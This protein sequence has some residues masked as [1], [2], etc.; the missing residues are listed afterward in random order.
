MDNKNEDF[1]FDCYSIFFDTCPREIKDD[2]G[3]VWTMD[4]ELMS[5]SISWDCE[6]LPTDW[7]VY[8][9]PYWEGENII[10]FEV[11]DDE[12]ELVYSRHTET[13]NKDF[14]M[15]QIKLIMAHGF[16]MVM[17]NILNRVGA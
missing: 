8:C 7:L 17:E 16:D 3:R 12:G 11:L 10:P 13:D 6:D 1:Y 9:T 14:D 2:S 15:D 5:G 4:R